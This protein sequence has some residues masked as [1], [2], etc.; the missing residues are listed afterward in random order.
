LLG[1][2]ES[3]LKKAVDI[4]MGMGLTEKEINQ[5][6][7]DKQVDMVE[8]Q[9][10]FRCG[11]QNHSPDKCFRNAMF[12]RGRTTSAQNVSRKE[13][14]LLPRTTLQYLQF[15]KAQDRRIRAKMLNLYHR[16]LIRYH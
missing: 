2:A 1:E 11:K 8:Y 16:I 9:A 4:N 7:N 10:G 6:S 15:K 14:E 3:S 12:A 5:F 13:R